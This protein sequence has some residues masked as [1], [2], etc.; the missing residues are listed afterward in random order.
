MTLTVVNG[1]IRIESA[2]IND[3]VADQT[4]T[5]SL[6]IEGCDTTTTIS[7]SLGDIT[8]GATNYLTY[9]P[10][11]EC[12]FNITL[13]ETDTNIKVDTACVL[14]YDSCQLLR[15][16]QTR[17]D[18]YKYIIYKSLTQLNTCQECSCQDALDIWRLYQTL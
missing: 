6:D 17:T 16:Y 2:L 13:T 11:E 3:Y 15:E 9:T 10:E 8:V 18:P 4:P 7:V 5:L 14:V 1:E 12:V